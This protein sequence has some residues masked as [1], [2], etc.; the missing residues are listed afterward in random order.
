M[1]FFLKKK[2]PALSKKEALWTL[3]IRNPYLE[4]SKNEEG[5]AVIQIPRRKDWVG[6]V[7]SLVFNPPEKRQLVLDKIG[8]MVWDLADGEHTFEEIVRTIK[9]EFK[10]TR[11]EA[12]VGVAA[13][14]RELGKRKLIVLAVRKEEKNGAKRQNI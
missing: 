5:E 9:R 13:F 2:T 6:R 14:L 11:R 1:P 10:L 7:L 12:E 8:T 4:W 3:P